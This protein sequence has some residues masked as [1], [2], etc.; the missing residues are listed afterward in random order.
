[1]RRAPLS[2]FARRLLVP[3]RLERPGDR[4]RRAERA[5]GSVCVDAGTWE[6][7]RPD[8]SQ[9]PKSVLG[10]PDGGWPG[11]RWL[12]IRQ[13]SVLEPIVNKRLQLCKSKNF[14]GVDPDNL[15]GYE[16]AILKHLGLNAWIVTCPR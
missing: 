15:D 9:F 3:R 4:L 6:K 8:A 7:W 14:D 16:T 13:T 10:L 11:E 1:P 12:D 5:L 2:R